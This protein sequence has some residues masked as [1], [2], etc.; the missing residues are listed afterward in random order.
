MKSNRVCH[1]KEVPCPD[2]GPSSYLQSLLA[3]PEFLAMLQALYSGLNASM[4]TESWETPL[5]SLQK[6]VYQGDPLSVVI[7]NTVMNTL[8]DT[9]STRINLGYQFSASS[10]RINILHY[11]DDTCLVA[12]SPASCQ[13]LL[14]MMGKWRGGWTGVG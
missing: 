12:N 2:S 5:V 6:G 11:A 4:I 14:S 1:L 10:R 7:F 3:P 9:V 13:H 8:V